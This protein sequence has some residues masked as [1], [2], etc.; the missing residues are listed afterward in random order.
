[1]T[2]NL[3]R[4]T[5]FRYLSITA[6]IAACCAM[7][8]LASGNEYSTS[9]DGL[10]SLQGEKAVSYLKQQGLYSSLAEAMKAARYKVYQTPESRQAVAAFYADNPAQG[11]S[12]KFGPDGVNLV[13]SD[14]EGERAEMS[15][16]LLSYGYGNRQIAVLSGRL[17]TDGNRVEIARE[18]G[19][20]G[21]GEQ[22]SHRGSEVR[23]LSPPHGTAVGV[24]TTPAPLHRVVRQPPR[25]S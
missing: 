4:H 7:V 8:F 22:G 25:W 14:K 21:A 23:T 20:R 11:Y 13:L 18:L 16:R 5:L 3:R 9:R 19:S 15:M 17:T 1:M 12:T 10:P 6:V 24:P 2:E